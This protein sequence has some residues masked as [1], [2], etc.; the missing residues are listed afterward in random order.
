MP[1]TF[2]TTTYSGDMPVFWRGEAKILPG[3][4]KLLQTFP[5]GTV[6]RKGTFL[7]IDLGTLTAGI[8]KKTKVLAGGTTTKPRVAK[9]HYF[10]GGDILMKMGETTGATIN[11]VD[12][13]NSDYDVLTISPAITGLAADDYLLE[14]TATTDAE[15]KF[16]PNAVVGEDTDPL[17]GTDRDTVSGSY[18]CVVLLGYIPEFPKEWLQ[19][20]TLKN[21]PNIV[22]AKQ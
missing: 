18:D 22:F 9:G 12:T 13:S 15:H 8:V 10:Q 2:S 16:E 11:S 3:G 1:I 6:I 4:F 14:A 5:K 7:S 19:G 21:N 17:T 20:I